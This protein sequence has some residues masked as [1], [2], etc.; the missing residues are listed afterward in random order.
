MT[1]GIAYRVPELGAVLVSDGRISRDGC[2][3]LT[4][5][6]RKFAVCGPIGVLVAGEIG[7]FWRQL[8]ES[9]PRSFAGFRKAVDATKEDTEWLAYDRSSGRLWLGDVRVAGLFT[10]IGSGDTLALG[11]LEALPLART[12]EDAER[13]GRRAVQI[14]CKYCFE[15]GGKVRALIMPRKGAP[16]LR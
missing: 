9:P 5:D 2:G 10:A 1:V 15:C 6:A 8:Q 14:A 11:A 13:A 16:V 3:A 7:A 4:N 12:L